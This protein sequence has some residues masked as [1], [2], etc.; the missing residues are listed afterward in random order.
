MRLNFVRKELYDYINGTIKPMY[1]TFDKAHNL[2]HFKFVTENCVN[3]AQSLIDKG[4]KIDL[5]IAYVVG[6]YHDVGISMGRDGHAKSSGQIVRSDN[7]LKE[8]FNEE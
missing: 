6:A 7:R 1:K 4:E 8:F 3:Y 2:S 5:E